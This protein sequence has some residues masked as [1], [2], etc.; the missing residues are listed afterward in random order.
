ML[1][2][3]EQE[4]PGYKRI[5][6]SRS[7]DAEDEHSA[8]FYKTD[9]V[10]VTDHGQFWLSETPDKV[11]S[12][13]WDSSLPRICTWGIFRSIKDPSYQFAFY[14]THLDHAGQ[15]ARE[16]GARVILDRMKSHMHQNL[17]T[18]VTGDMN[19]G[20]ENKAVHILNS[21]S[22]QDVY[23][24]LNESPG[25]TFHGFKGGQ[26]GE[27]IDYIFTSDHVQV[28]K[29]TVDRNVVDGAYLSDHYPVIAQLE[30]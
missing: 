18:L 13:S 6:E 21:E 12:K 30:I 27:T 7:A 25:G 9:K 19:A 2:D 1:Q 15:Q 14:N 4:L 20:P 11:G 10:E 17:S 28:L 26:D 3:L 29:V 5:G 24:E 22:L 8:I 16:E 23:T